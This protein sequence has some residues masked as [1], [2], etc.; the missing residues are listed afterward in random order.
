MGGRIILKWILGKWYGVC[1]GLI[2]LRMG[3][4]E[5]SCDHSNRSSDS[6]KCWEIPQELSD[7]WVLQK[8]SAGVS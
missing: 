7:G 4:V 8:D 6:I 2:R 3:P 1:T 5:G